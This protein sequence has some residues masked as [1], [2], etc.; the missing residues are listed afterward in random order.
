MDIPRISAAEME[1]KHVVRVGDCRGSDLAYLDQRIPGHE[2]EIVNVVGMNVTE[3]LEDPDLEPKVGK[4][5][6]FS[7]VYNRAK[8]GSGSGAALHAHQT[9]EIFVPMIGSWEV[10]WLEGEDERAVRL[11]PL[12]VISVPIGIY[13]GFRLV[14]GGADSLMLAIVGGPDAGHVS[15]HPSVIERAR[16]TGLEVDENGNLRELD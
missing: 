6:G 11:D 8:E 3:N 2:R 5:H 1:A 12:D 9:E 10:F 16:E 15:W 13:R 14:E 7:L 4:A